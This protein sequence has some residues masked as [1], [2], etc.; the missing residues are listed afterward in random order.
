M[1][2]LD[3]ALLRT[4]LAFADSGSLTHAAGSVGRTPSAVTAQVQR[5]EA[6]LG[7]CLLA[8]S[9]RGRVLT[10]AGEA[11]VPHAR[12]ALNALRDAR[13]GVSGLLAS[14]RVGL[15]VTQD[16]ADEGLPP[17]LRSFA[18]S[19]PRLRVDLRVCSTAGL[20]EDLASGKAD[21]I[22][23]S[24]SGGV[25]LP[26]VEVATLREKMV[27]LAGAGGLAVPL[28]AGQ[29][30]SAELPLALVDAPCAFREAAL[31]A[32]TVAGRAH[33]IAASSSSVAGLRAAVRAG[34]ALT[35]RT[36]RFA[37]GGIA[38]A[39]ASYA[40]PKL[41]DAAFSLRVKQDADTP[42]RALAELLMEGFR[43]RPGSHA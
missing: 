7:T 27:W 40:L 30:A 12:R 2:H 4:F 43:A 11:L 23:L 3:P 29:E 18:E 10:E 24:R 36:R 19:H 14:G 38:V 1:E 20:A 13:L 5:L 34:L 15:G 6:D 32:L 26:G 16:F 21:V 22:L 35:A 28:P 37:G 33:R 31:S 8:P 42:A 9:G 17:L 41:P 39:P 25:E